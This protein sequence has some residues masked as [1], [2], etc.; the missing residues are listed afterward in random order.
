MFSA[1]LMPDEMEFEI[2]NQIIFS[3]NYLYFLFI[4]RSLDF[5]NI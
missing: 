3:Q 2:Y 4:Q 1:Q 5:E